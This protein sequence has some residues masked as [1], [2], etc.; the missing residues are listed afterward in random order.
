[1][2]SRFVVLGILLTAC[3]AAPIPPAARFPAGTRI[4][5]QY[6]VIDA[7]ELRYVEAGQG[8]PVIFIHGLAASIYAWRKNLAPVAAAGFRVV[9]FDNRG[10]GFSAKPVHGYANADYVRLVIAL[11]DSLRIADA[12]LVGHS[13]GGAIAAQV[14]LEHPHR[15]RGLVLL[16]AAIGP[17]TRAP[18]LWRLC[19][20]P[21]F[22]SML[23][24]LRG[25]SLT[26]RVL[27]STYA[28]PAKVTEQDVDQYYAPV[29]DPDFGR[30]LLAMLREFR[31]DTLEGRLG[32]LTA[33]TL[34][35]WGEQDRWVPPGVGRRLASQLLRAAFVTVPHAGH[36]LQE[37]AAEEVN[38]L[39][40]TFLKH[41]LPRI[42]ENLAWSSR[43][44][45][46]AGRR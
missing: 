19:R 29:A 11:M 13:M 39:L 2:T 21:A 25:R 6:R 38:R 26:A 32:T 31:F 17:G 46:D 5:A 34:L 12:V 10:F 23:M 36:S 43:S 1:M 40:I 42:P 20:W 3:R 18:T 45:A 30:A 14:A 37:E 35:L 44:G 7:A 15:V 9:A 27:K 41:G 4:Q 24:R 28:D 16:A 33:P 8:T 22:G